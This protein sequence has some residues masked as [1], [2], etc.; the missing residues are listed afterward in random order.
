MLKKYNN[1]FQI[2]IKQRIFTEFN[3]QTTIFEV[4]NIL[5]IRNPHPF[6]IEKAKKELE[7]INPK[8][9][10]NERMGRWNG[11]T[12]QKLKFYNIDSNGN[13]T[14]P[15]G[16][17]REYLKFCSANKIEFIISDHR[18]NIGDIEFLFNGELKSFQKRAVHDVF[19]KDFGI[20]NAPTG[21]G[22]TV[23]ALY[24]IY[25]RK[26]P[27]LVIVHTKDLARQWIE[28]ASRFLGIDRKEIGLI[29][30]GQ[31]KE[32]KK[33]TIGLVQSLVKYKGDLE[34]RIGH[35]IVDECHRTPSKTFTDVVSSFSSKYM[36]GLSA[37]PYRRDNLSNLIFWYIGNLRHKIEKQNLQIRGHITEAEI[38]LRP[39]QFTPFHDPV[40]EYSKMMT[41]LT[42]DNER[43]RLIA[44]DIAKEYKNSRGHII[45]LSDRKKHCEN[46][47][48]IL[49][50]GHRLDSL[51]F[52][53][54][55]SEKKRITALQ[56]L[57]SQKNSIII[58][59]GQ[60]IGEG[61][62]LSSLSTL[63]LATPVNFRG[64]LTQYLGRVLRTAPGKT[65]AV[66]YDYVDVN[67][68]VL[69]K[70]ALSRAAVY[71]LKNLPEFL[72]EF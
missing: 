18:T 58:A 68:H 1:K 42:A 70:S 48:Q 67:V 7:I 13:L 20:L 35:L 12:R 9:S 34:S 39:T 49:K 51:V 21:S 44:S 66:V 32:G 43:N 56:K 61:F 64:R 53:G 65:K 57:I 47:S 26:Q 52:T 30:G 71:G 5:T 60:L 24:L 22:K 72:S 19:S 46:L 33:L 38:I 45:V 54:D 31:K 16:L 11:K 17:S 10:E 8:W 28:Q 2:K 59:T 41:E 3:L 14:I 50:F 69:K 25:L 6:I 4:K 23:M 40:T 36:L 37:T 27:A 55:L 15:R 63:F 62:D 29:G